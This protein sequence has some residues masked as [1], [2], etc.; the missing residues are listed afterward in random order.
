MTPS[1]GLPAA[2]PRGWFVLGPVIAIILLAAL[3]ASWPAGAA[4]PPAQLPPASD[5]PQ[6]T[7]T[8][9]ATP[10]ATP[11][12]T[13]AAATPTATVRADISVSKT[14]PP[15]ARRLEYFAYRVSLTNGGPSTTSSVVTDTL[16]S[17]LLY[18]GTDPGPGVTCGPPA[19]RNVVCT[20]VNQPM[21]QTRVFTITVRVDGNASGTITNNLIARSPDDPAPAS[22]QLFTTVLVDTV[23]PTPT[24]AVATPDAYECN[25]HPSIASRVSAGQAAITLNFVP[26]LPGSCGPF[27]GGND[28]DYFV[29]R[30]KAGDWYK[31]T[32]TVQASIDT[33]MRLYN[34]DQDL[35]AE[36]DDA[37]GGTFASEII[38]LAAYDGDYYLQ[39]TDLDPAQIAGAVY[40]FRVENISSGP[41]ATP[42]TPTPTGTPGPTAV[43]GLDTC[44]PNWDFDHACVVAPGA[45]LS[46]MNFISP[47][48]GAP[49]NDFYR[50]WQK[51]GLEYRCETAS[52]SA[53]LDTNIIVYNDQRIGVGGNDDCELGVFSSC[54]EWVSAYTGWV[55][56]LVGS[57]SQPPPPGASYTFQCSVAAPTTPTP[58]PTNTA[59][60]TIPIPLV[61]ATFA[62]PPTQEPQP[63]TPPPLPPTATP[64][65]IIV[66]L[67]TPTAGGGTTMVVRVDV[68]IYYDIDGDEVPDSDEG[69][70][71]V[72]AQLL[73]E[74]G[75]LLDSRLTDH[76][77]VVRLSAVAHGDI[78]LD[79]PY[80]TVRVPISEARTSV[81]VRIVPQ[82]VPGTIP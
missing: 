4:A 18:F 44:E 64:G 22:F 53:G 1:T 62:A 70:I 66:P 57:V 40:T 55:Y 65:I 43:P 69:V 52:L 25:N 2:A 42:V 36:N 74:N 30:T 29:V 15:S 78:V 75:G 37:F 41:T 11:T 21:G 33:Y 8:D 49:D 27:G 54:L 46:G 16:H 34:H 14:G 82:P 63:I 38:W 81:Q 71:G 72:R 56:F 58:V 5:I 28:V 7:P 50:L 12:A 19:G 6:Q 3:L 20:M 77:G 68:Q 76:N 13:T 51:P 45:A 59:R 31:A 47:Q 61:T 39:L 73:D 35:I 67:A 80:F 79:I 10:T 48:P 17:S 24:G 60:P 23:T 9:T 26:V 32:T